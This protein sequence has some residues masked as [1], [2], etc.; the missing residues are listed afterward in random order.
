[1]SVICSKFS[2]LLTIFANTCHLYCNNTFFSRQFL[3]SLY[4]L[5]LIHI[6][7]HFFPILWE[8][9]NVYQPYFQLTSLFKFN[10]NPCPTSC[11][12]FHWVYFLKQFSFSF[13]SFSFSFSFSFIS[14]LTLDS[15]LIFDNPSRRVSMNSVWS[16]SLMEKQKSLYF[17]KRE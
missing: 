2:K 8:F 6:R 10:Q 17:Y 5:K 16:V 1:M 12:K 11:A 4:S 13:F 15:L 3:V 7:G 14:I 9:F